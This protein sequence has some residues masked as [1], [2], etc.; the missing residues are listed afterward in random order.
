MTPHWRKVG[1]SLAQHWPNLVCNDGPMLGHWTTQGWANVVCRH[2]PNARAFKIWFSS[3]TQEPL[4]LLKSSCYFWVPQTIYYQMHIIF[5]KRCWWFWDRA[6]YML[7]FGKGCSTPL[8]TKQKKTDCAPYTF[9]F[10]FC[11]MVGSV[12]KVQLSGQVVLELLIKTIFWRLWHWASIGKQ[13]WP[14]LVLSNG[15]TSGHHCTLGWANVE[16]MICQP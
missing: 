9:F 1:R 5:S 4:G 3:T 8:I 15:P 14:N 13:H 2:W 7:I 12:S 6:Q 10:L 16:L 11:S